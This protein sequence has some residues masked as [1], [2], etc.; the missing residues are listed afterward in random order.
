MQV[1]FMYGKCS[2][3]LAVSGITVQAFFFFSFLFFLEGVEGGGGV[4]SDFFH[5]DIIG[6]G[7]YFIVTSNLN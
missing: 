3:Y 2:D 7:D 1:Y 4:F 6:V 5:K